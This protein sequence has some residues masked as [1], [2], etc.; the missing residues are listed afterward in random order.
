MAAG[1][2]WRQRYF[3]EPKELSVKKVGAWTL[4]GAIANFAA[5]SH[6]HASI[7]WWLPDG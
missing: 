6:D 7:R 5:Q 1:N 4:F 2:S 3:D